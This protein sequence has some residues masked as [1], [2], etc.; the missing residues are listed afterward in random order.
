MRRLWRCIA[1][2][3]ATVGRLSFAG[4]VSVFSWYQ[5]ALAVRQAGACGSDAI[6]E[7]LA[8]YAFVF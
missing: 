5:E 8:T 1:E 2:A 6:S 7:I 3:F 4:N